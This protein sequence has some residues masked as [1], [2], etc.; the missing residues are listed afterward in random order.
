MPAATASAK[1]FLTALPIGFG[2]P[3]AS[4]NDLQIA[5]ILEPVAQRE[6]VGVAVPLERPAHEGLVEAAI[7]PAAAD[8]AVE[9]L[10]A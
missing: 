4:A 5:H 2:S 10:R 8:H 6:L 1:L 3:A 7:H 9:A